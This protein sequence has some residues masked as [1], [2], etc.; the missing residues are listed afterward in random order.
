[1]KNLKKPYA[2]AEKES[3]DCVKMMR[4]PGKLL[5]LEFINFMG[6]VFFWGIG[7]YGCNAS[8]LD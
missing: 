8:I 3:G 4:F 2:K 5:I 7:N 6:L 1:M